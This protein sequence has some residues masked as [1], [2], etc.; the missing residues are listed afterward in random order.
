M[1]KLELSYECSHC[2]KV[3]RK[4]VDSREIYR[5][6]TYLNLPEGWSVVSLGLGDSK[7]VVCPSCLEEI[8][9][10]LNLS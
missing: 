5:S 1:I 6:Q 3:E 10:F 2:R 9:R 4:Q 8:K 7:E